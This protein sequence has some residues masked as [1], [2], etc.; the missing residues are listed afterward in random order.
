MQCKFGFWIGCVVSSLIFLYGCA[1][2]IKPDIP[3]HLPVL[4]E[5]KARIVFTREKQIAGADSPIIVID[6]GASIEPNAM[7]RLGG[8]TPEQILEQDNIASI[9]GIPVAFLWFD[10][11]A[12]KPL[13]C[14][15]NGPGCIVD[16]WKWPQRDWGGLLFG[17]GVSIHPNCM[18][19][20]LPLLNDQFYA[21]VMKH[22][23]KPVPIPV[24]HVC[25]K[26]HVL[27]PIELVL[28]GP[29]TNESQDR[30]RVAGTEWA[31]SYLLPSD[32]RYVIIDPFKKTPQSSINTA[33]IIR[34]HQISR[35]VQ[36]IGST[37]VGETLIWDRKPGIMRLGTVWYDATGFMPKNIEVEAGKTYF[38]RYT[39][40][41]GQRWELE[42]IE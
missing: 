26:N 23:L 14:A 39:T 11:T 19:E 13:Y 41:M 1:G 29:M 21:Q 37:E 36:V 15:D 40:R 20:Y 7:I 42:K 10:R 6:I 25:F 4:G 9:V 16:H 17:S 30:M 32:R 38:I 5:G 8:L 2:P 35:Q 33:A 3:K 18:L 12:V 27:G 31:E 24:D 28:T 22:E 34:N